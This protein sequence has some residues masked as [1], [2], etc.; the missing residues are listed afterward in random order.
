M[1][2]MGGETAPWWTSH[3]TVLQWTSTTNPP[4]VCT[5]LPGSVLYLT[6]LHYS[7]LQC[8]TGRMCGGSVQAAECLHA[9]HRMPTTMV[10]G[11]KRP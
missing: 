4:L 6:R 11:A 9:A 3:C 5:A 7:R 8:T 2:G 10:R 1:V